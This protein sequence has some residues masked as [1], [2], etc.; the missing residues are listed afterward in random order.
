MVTTIARL[1]VSPV[2]FLIGKLH[3]T[4]P[5]KKKLTPNGSTESV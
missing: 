4:Y 1:S 5:G 2:L 3:E